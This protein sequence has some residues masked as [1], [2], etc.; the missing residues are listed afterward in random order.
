MP[1]SCTTSCSFFP[2]RPGKFSLTF[3]W[4][5]VGKQEKHCDPDDPADTKQGDHWDHVALDAEHRL[6]V[7]VV[8][9]KRT[10]E[11]TERLMKDFKQRTGGKRMNLITSD[12]YAPYET[13]IL[14]AYGRKI[15]P[16]PTGKPGRPKSVDSV[17]AADLN[18]ATVQKTRK[19]GRVVKI[20]FRVVFGTLAAV[21]AALAVSLVA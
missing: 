4:S 16:S 10:T 17:P 11:N 7:S 14:K 2:L 6:V 20:D 15:V 13:A 21:Q 5:F 9:G 8:P 19:Q 1:S 18:Y 12:E 3:K